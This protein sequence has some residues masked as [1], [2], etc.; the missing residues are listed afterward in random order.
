MIA[1]FDLIESVKLYGS[2]K[3]NIFEVHDIRLNNLSNCELEV[4][5]FER[6]SSVKEDKGKNILQFVSS[7]LFV[8][9]NLLLITMIHKLSPYFLG[10]HTI[11][12]LDIY[13]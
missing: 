3:G 1:H 13:I 2:K 12:L 10:L 8:L 5:T 4:G 11:S 7:C 6:C 9:K